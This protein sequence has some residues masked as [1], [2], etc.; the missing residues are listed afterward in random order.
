MS[1]MCVF[2]TCYCSD[3]VTP[4]KVYC[5]AICPAR[6][7]VMLHVAYYVAVYVLPPKSI[8]FHAAHIHCAT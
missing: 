4:G 2:A 8:D 7:S 3:A 5:L 1:V 6:Q